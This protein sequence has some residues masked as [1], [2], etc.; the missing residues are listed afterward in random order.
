MFEYAVNYFW[1]DRKSNNLID[2]MSD[3]L[4]EG[5]GSIYVRVLWP[6]LISRSC[7]LRH[8]HVDTFALLFMDY[9][10]TSEMITNVGSLLTFIS[11]SP[12]PS[13]CLQGLVLSADS[14][15]SDGIGVYHDHSE[16]WHAGMGTALGQ[17]STGIRGTLWPV[18]SDFSM[19]TTLSFTFFW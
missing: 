9:P 14:R 13:L 19:L 8:I 12:S 11:N 10:R 7:L 18:S 5:T 1:L 6:F 17:T 15:W 2:R 16:H 4:S 3:W